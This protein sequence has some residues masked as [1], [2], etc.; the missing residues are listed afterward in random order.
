[1]EMMMMMMLLA[2]RGDGSS[3]DPM[4]EGV[5]ISYLWFCHGRC[6]ASFS[7]PSDFM[8]KLPVIKALRTAVVCLLHFH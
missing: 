3:G 5:T 8:A 6:I 4:E 7:L 1:M 2:N